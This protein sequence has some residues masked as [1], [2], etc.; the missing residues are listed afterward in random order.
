MTE[1]EMNLRMSFDDWFSSF[2]I[3]EHRSFGDAVFLLKAFHEQQI[4]RQRQPP[5]ALMRELQ[6]LLATLLRYLL[7]GVLDIK[8]F[9][10]I[11]KINHGA[12]VQNFFSW[13]EITRFFCAWLCEA[14]RLR[15]ACQGIIGWCIFDTLW[16]C[17][18]TKEK[19]E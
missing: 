3:F 5:S 4:H 7:Q 8:Q 18:I 14:P 12:K 10:M 1:V 6:R 2:E 19:N 11:V 17:R 15:C 16:S 13:T 9:S